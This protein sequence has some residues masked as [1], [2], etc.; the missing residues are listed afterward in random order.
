MGKLTEKLGH[1]HETAFSY[2]NKAITLNLSAVD[3]FY[4]M[5]ASRLK[6]LAESGKQNMGLLQVVFLLFLFFVFYLKKNRNQIYQ[7]SS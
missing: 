5:H 6:L 2:Y 7:T 4:R 1:Q 3:S